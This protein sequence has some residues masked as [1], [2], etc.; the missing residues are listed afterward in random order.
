MLLPR[1][2]ILGLALLGAVSLVAE[3]M[4]TR[5]YH[6]PPDFIPPFWDGDTFDPFS[7]QP[8]PDPPG[9]DSRKVLEAAGVDFPPGASC[10]FDR[11][12]NLLTV[13]NT[14]EN[15][16]LVEIY[17]GTL[18]K[19]SPKTI[20]WR[21][22]IIELPTSKL[23][24][25]Q[26]ADEQLAALHKLAVQPDSGVR[27]IAAMLMEGKPG[28]RL[29]QQSALER[30]SLRPPK[31]DDEGNDTIEVDSRAV[32]VQLEL[33]SIISSDD[34]TIET[35]IA[36]HAPVP[37]PVSRQLKAGDPLSGTA[38]EL[39][40]DDVREVEW[41][42]GISHSPGETKL[43]GVAASPWKD[44]WQ[45]AAFL[46][47]DVLRYDHRGMFALFEPPPPEFKAPP[48]MTA[49]TIH[50]PSGAY[51]SAIPGREQ[52][53]LLTWLDS[54]SL[55]SPGSSFRVE[56][57]RLHIVNT[58]QN[59]DRIAVVVHHVGTHQRKNVRA[60]VNTIEAPIA[61]FD[62]TEQTDDDAL[63]E[64]LEQAATSGEARFIDTKA[65]ENMGGA[66]ATS[67]AADDHPMLTSIKID[68]KGHV[69][70]VI[71][72]RPT[73]SLL[74]LE[75][76][77]G[78]DQQYIEMNLSHELHA[79]PPHTRQGGYIAP[80]TSKHADL[81]LTDF[82]VAK[83]ITGLTLQNGRQRLFAVYQPPGDVVVDKLWFTFI[84]A[85]VAS[86]Y[87]APRPRLPNPLPEVRPPPGDPNALEVGFFRVPPDF[88]ENGEG[89][90]K[91]AKE[92]LE[93]ESITFP[94]GAS[95]TFIP[96][97]SR[98]VVRNTRANVDLVAAFVENH[99]KA[100]P[101]GVALTSQL[102]EASGPVLRQFAIQ[103]AK[104]SNHES[105]LAG[106]LAMPEVKQLDLSH[107][108][109]RSGQRFT[110]DAGDEVTYLASIE[111]DKHGKPHVSHK[112]RRVGLR[113]E[114]EPFLDPNRQH[115][116]LN[117]WGEWH[118]AP[119][120]QL[121]EHL[122]DANGRRFD[123]PL[124]VFHTHTFTSAIVMSDGTTHLVSLWKPVGV[125]KDVLQALFITARIVP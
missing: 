9:D 102:I 1:V 52:D 110:V 75:P 7:Y 115:I 119:P 41:V 8:M 28:A 37:P 122:S 39:P 46:R 88:L 92:I 83:T 85:D 30:S 97:N 40:V 50:M 19:L 57:D 54:P 118:T 114:C 124:T 81:P 38:V 42:T 53:S 17:A 98:L 29:T 86:Q 21:L 66:R 87:A 111:T 58:R 36:I 55:K 35:N 43:V 113:L 107:I 90:R 125:E 6:I 49:V 91:T 72:S 123:L 89:K 77:L 22:E 70:P 65:F 12:I 121:A 109:G 80:G 94:K 95:A 67:S 112:Q 99:F 100:S 61:M 69:W 96:A 74:D 27:R 51:A 20:R 103:S 31:R 23:V 47:A 48:G 33:E 64:K 11:F 34:K 45:L 82:K 73:G 59:I 68:P 10:R 117:F 93:E 105:L 26:N 13:H 44:G 78:Q 84:R 79:G 4:Q 60:V 101:R 63:F 24:A 5:V 116:R 25:D 16:E 104:L 76:T 71:D 56:G 62:E 120:T 15:L 108:E 18:I 2:F 3:E 32:G 14:R 106:L